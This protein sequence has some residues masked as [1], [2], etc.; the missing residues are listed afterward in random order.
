MLGAGVPPYA[1][2]G[3]DPQSVGEAHKFCAFL[4]AAECPF[5]GKGAKVLGIM[6]EMLQ[7]AWE[8]TFMPMD[9]KLMVSWFT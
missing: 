2:V 4:A 7:E 1:F 6:I 8:D 5:D 9:E 3:R